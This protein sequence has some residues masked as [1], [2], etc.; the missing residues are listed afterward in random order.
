MLEE[1]FHFSVSTLCYLRIIFLYASVA[2]RPW[3]PNS[4]LGICL[5]SVILMVVM[6]SEEL[7]PGRPE[8]SVPT[9][10]CCYLPSVCVYHNFCL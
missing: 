5:Q 8:T 1:Q 2:S 10:L 7:W 3:N 9:R 6:L 4:N